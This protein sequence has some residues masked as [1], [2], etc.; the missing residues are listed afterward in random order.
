MKT[1]YDEVI[2]QPVDRLAQTMQ[3]MTYCYHETAVP[4]AHYKK[5]L[6]KAIEGVVAESV[7]LNMV[8]AFYKT[9]TEFSKGNRDWY[10]ATLL[11]IELGVNP[12]KAS[13]QQNLAIQRLTSAVSGGEVELLNPALKTAYTNEAK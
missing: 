9:L 4:K 8:N 5:L 3:D 6:G 2:K 13:A 10:V 11:S 12:A 7:S 1:T